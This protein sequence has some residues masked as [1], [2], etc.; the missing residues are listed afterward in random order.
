MALEIDRVGFVGIGLL[1]KMQDLVEDFIEGREDSEEEEAA[2]ETEELEDEEKKLKDRLE[3]LAD[4]GEERY[5]EWMD[6]QKEGREKVSDKMKE[7]AN[8]VFSELGLVTQ[9][10][11]EELEAKIA[12]L[13]RAV[14][15]ASASKK[16]S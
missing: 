9:E 4:L 13:Q 12:K 1:A 2:V 11:I 16:S 10:D 8:N 3:E 14:K 7:R 15:K 5:D 6:K